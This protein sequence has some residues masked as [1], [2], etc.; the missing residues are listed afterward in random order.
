M[1]QILSRYGSL[2][3]HRLSSIIR[4]IHL[5][6]KSGVLHLS[7]KG[8]SKRL[9]FNAGSIVFAG[10]DDEED[11]WGEVL[12]REGKIK[13]SDLD[14]AWEVMKR[15][16]QGL[17]ETIVEMGFMTP[18]EIDTQVA[19]RM[20]AIIYSSFTWQSGKYSFKE[21]DNPVADDIAMDLSPSHV[22]MEGIRRI[23][24]PATI[25]GLLGDL[26]GVIRQPKGSG[27]PYDDNN[28]TP[29]ERVILDLARTRADGSSTGRALVDISPLDEDQTL[30]CL[31]CLVSLGALE[32]E[33]S[34]SEPEAAARRTGPAPDV[35]DAMEIGASSANLP[36]RLGRYE[37]QKL[38]GRGSMGTV[39]LARDPEIERIV[40]IKLIQAT[41]FLTARERERYRN[42]FRREAKAAG[43]LIHPGI[44]TVF[45]LGY[46]DE[47]SPF[48]VMEYVPG[49]TLAALVQEEELS[50]EET[51]RLAS[52]VLEAL[53]YAH[54]AGIVHRDIK[55]ANILVT[56]D[57]H[58]KI[59]DFGIAHVVGTQ[60]TPTE[61]SMGSPNYMAPEQLSKGTID[62]RTDLFSFGV[63]LYRLLTGRLPFT[64]DSFAAGAQAILSEE[65]VRPE[66]IN[67]A[68][69]PGL[70]RIVLRCL[71][72]N[73]EERF[74]SADEVNMALSL[75]QVNDLWPSRESEP[76]AESPVSLPPPTSALSSGGRFEAERRP[77]RR[78]VFYAAIAML[79]L[80]GMIVLTLVFPG[81]KGSPDETPPL[82][83][84]LADDVKDPAED[85]G[86][87]QARKATTE[88]RENPE[89]SEE[90]SSEAQ[91]FYEAKTA[92]ERGDLEESMAKLEELLE[93]NP[94]FA[95]APQLLAEAREDVRTDRRGLGEVG[96][97]KANGS[98]TRWARPTEQQLFEDATLAR[99][100]GDLL[101][102]KARLEELLQRNPTFSGASELLAE[103]ADE[104]WVQE[105]L[106]LSFG[107]R[108]Q[109][110]LGDCAG[111]L[112][113]SASAIRFQSE[114]HEWNWNLDDIPVMQRT[115]GKTLILETYERE[116][117]GMSKSKRY[118]FLLVQP[119]E[120]ETWSQ[121]QRLVTGTA[122]AQEASQLEGQQEGS[123]RSP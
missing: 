29:Q 80:L 102:S 109:H 100:Y 70:S 76:S 88:E 69:S 12:V 1:S 55:P 116:I 6:G 66:S 78:R 33:K 41:T 19:R 104:I 64:G 47:E 86:V 99:Q 96:T 58:A 84:D 38:L 68:V 91:L 7:N 112:S 62:Q 49:Q 31:C 85:D 113:L 59:M 54:C 123:L 26:D 51:V 97:G 75:G 20:T 67:L 95:G 93:R 82:Q 111:T 92:L 13:R 4:S 10:S 79:V 48:I 30:R 107:A 83:K 77:V 63:V 8:V 37:I 27:L 28:L 3:Q 105:T 14:L 60:L 21:L 45:D 17:T 22:I 39:F 56:S 94:S 23:Q 90:H 98:P 11:Q 9:Y 121:Y 42:R 115:D 5:G 74:A 15:T 120:L 65:P 122:A 89:A 72:K 71:A 44:V 101:T 25:L 119:L 40:A 43:R 61:Q 2:S 53:S 35:V 52:E 117:L 114:A 18:E 50:A 24:D 36:R 32:L 108:H 110:R 34:R 106:P 16:G 46:A 81:G 57:L 103:V 118:R 73:P 87:L